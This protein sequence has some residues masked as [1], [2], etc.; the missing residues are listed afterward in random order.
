MRVVCVRFDGQIDLQR[1]AESCFILSPQIALG[2]KW[3]F[4]EIGAC[5]KLYSEQTM[6]GRLQVLLKKFNLRAQV[7]IANDIPTS[8]ALATFGVQQ[9]TL[10]PIEALAIYLDPFS[11]ANETLKVPT[12]LRK[13]GISN[14]TEVLRIPRKSLGVRFGKDI[15]FAVDRMESA[16]HIPWPTFTPSNKL[17]ETEEIDDAYYLIDLEPLSFL[18]KRIL[19]R[20][21]LRLKGLGKLASV[22]E[23]RLTQEKY[24]SVSDPVR[25]F[26]ITLTFPQRSVLPLLSMIRDRL[27]HALSKEPLEAPLRFVELEISESVFGNAQQMNFFSKK[28]EELEEF[29]SVITRLTEKLGFDRAFLATA[30]ESYTPEKSWSKTLLEPNCKAGDLPERPLRLLTKPIRVR[31]IEDYFSCAGKRWKALA[32]SGPERLSGEW[33][34]HEKCRDYF[35]IETKEGEELWIFQSEKEYYLHGIFD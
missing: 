29:R 18:L 21:M 23:I 22:I 4:I 28:E 27:N 1:F 13:L 2:H 14:L 11:E 6:Y 31:R 9:K 8:L 19:E 3:L 32:I 20:T 34:F 25:T 30:I 15:L 16:T 26:S 12:L 17:L 35:R 33:W 5:R 7:S 24:S 10:L